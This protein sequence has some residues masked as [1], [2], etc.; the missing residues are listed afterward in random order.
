LHGA[1]VEAAAQN[2]KYVIAR[3]PAVLRTS[4]VATA[5]CR[6]FTRLNCERPSRRQSG[7]ATALPNSRAPALIGQRLDREQRRR[8]A[9]LA[10][11]L[12]EDVLDVLTH[13]PR[14]GVENDRDLAVRFSLR[15]PE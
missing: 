5:L 12:F 2:A 10:T 6:R 8:S 7:V 3:T 13:R 15:D 9:I 14:T 11:G 4:A 1:H